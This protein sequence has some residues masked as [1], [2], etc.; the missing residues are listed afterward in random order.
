NAGGIVGIGDSQR[1]PAHHVRP[2]AR[3]A[4]FQHLVQPCPV[5]EEL[6][7][8]V[9]WALAVVNGSNVE[10]PVA[11]KDRALDGNSITDL[12]PELVGRLSS[13]DCA[14][15]VLQERAPLV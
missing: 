4:R 12:P 7:G 2:G 1:V 10:L 15:A 6:G 11:G 5:K 8:V 9:L 14:L 3:A 13:Y